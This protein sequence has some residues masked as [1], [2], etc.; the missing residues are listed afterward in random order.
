MQEFRHKKSLGQHFLKDQNIIRKIADSAEIEPEEKIWEIGPGK[1]VLTAEIL[2]RNNNL[3]CFEIDKTL[4]PILIEKFGEQITLVKSDILK[5]N[6]ADYLGTEKIKIVANLPYQITS[7]FLFE[8][9]KYSEHFSR[10]IV[11]IQKEV[12]QRIAAE[13]GSKNY[14]ILSLKMQYYFVPRYEFTVKPTVFV[15]PPKVDS[16]VISLIPRLDRPFV[17]DEKRFWRLVEVALRNRRKM[18]RRNLRELIG[19]EKVE[20]LSEIS[21]LDLKRR[22]ETLTEAEFIQLFEQV[23]QMR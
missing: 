23:E 15:P 1:G 7:P 22:G 14:G 17:S 13:V 21:A 5:I 9:A 2:K 8:V 11:M 10:V 19:K 12:A 18:L 6:W 3:T 20:K 4:Y 16:A